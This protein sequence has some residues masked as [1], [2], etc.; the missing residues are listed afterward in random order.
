MA[1][2]TW[3]K[4]LA[5]LIV[6]DLKRQQ[7]F[8]TACDIVGSWAHHVTERRYA[9]GTASGS[10]YVVQ[11]HEDGWILR[12]LQGTTLE[13]VFSEDYGFFHLEAIASNVET[14]RLKMKV[15]ANDE[16]HIIA[17]NHLEDFAAV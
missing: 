14:R 11:A 12:Q 13:R 15:V 6:N 5:E 2:G 1:T 4:Q 8:Q 9:L 17:S 3:G 16:R 10:I 7:R